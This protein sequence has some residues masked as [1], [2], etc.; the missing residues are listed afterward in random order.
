MYYKCIL[1][2]MYLR[3]VYRQNLVFHFA[4]KSIKEKI[5]PVNKKLD[6]A[7]HLAVVC[8]ACYL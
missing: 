1:L 8:F 6:K 5:P 7:L 2:Y 3:Q 4:K